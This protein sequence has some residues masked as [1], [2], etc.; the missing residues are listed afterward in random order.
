MNHTSADLQISQSDPV[1]ILSLL[2]IVIKPYQ[3]FISFKCHYANWVVVI[4]E[5]WC[6]PWKFTATSALTSSRPSVACMRQWIESAL[7]Q[8]KACRLFDTKT[9]SKPIPGH[10]QWDPYEQTS[11]EFES[12]YKT[13]HSWKC[14]W[15]RRLRNGGHFVQGEM[16]QFLVGGVWVPAI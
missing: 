16:S 14:M 15:K 4:I 3:W 9:L 7:V 1:N 2:C 6:L 10:C 13:F 12:K 5:I 8:I 11:V